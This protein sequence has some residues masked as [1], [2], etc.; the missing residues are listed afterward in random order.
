MK[1][2][3]P[4]NLGVSKMNYQDKSAATFNA[5]LRQAAKEG[6]LPAEFAQKVMSSK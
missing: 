4:N 6:K 1:G 2:I 5:K 3:G